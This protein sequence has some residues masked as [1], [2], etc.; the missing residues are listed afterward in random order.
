MMF[1]IPEYAGALPENQARSMRSRWPGSTP[2]PRA[3]ANAHDQLRQVLG[4]AHATIIE[5]ACVH[6]S[7]TG[8]LVDD[9]TLIAD[10]PA[11]ESI[12]EALTTLATHLAGGADEARSR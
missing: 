1:S 8:A 2:H 9:D 6:V 3:A 12:V 4:Y 5:P 11:Q 10:V 7:I